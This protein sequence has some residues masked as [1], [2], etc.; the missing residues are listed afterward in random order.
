MRFVIVTGM[1]GAG[2]S[3]ALKMLEDVGYF[4]IDNLPLALLPKLVEILRV[5]ST[6][7]NKVSLEL[8]FEAD[9][10]LLIWKRC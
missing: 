9:R 6:E 5:P 10:I 1:S 3:T 7:F 8:I 4:C 2:K